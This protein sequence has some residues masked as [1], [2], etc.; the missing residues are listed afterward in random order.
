MIIFLICVFFSHFK[1]K[2]IESVYL[3]QQTFRHLIYTLMKSAQSYWALHTRALLSRSSGKVKF[4]SS[5]WY[6]K[7]GLLRFCGDHVGVAFFFSQTTHFVPWLQSQF[8]KYIRWNKPCLQLILKALS[9]RHSLL[10]DAAWPRTISIDK[11][12]ILSGT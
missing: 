6:V 4:D 9:P 7:A 8:W 11:K 3:H 10:V 12:K 1:A 5:S 2:K